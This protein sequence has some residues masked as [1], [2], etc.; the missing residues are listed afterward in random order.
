M[1]KEFVY[2]T[3]YCVE[4]YFLIPCS[5]KWIPP[6]ENI[7]EAKEIFERIVLRS[8]ENDSA[9]YK[10]ILEALEEAIN[11]NASL[12][13]KITSNNGFIKV[14]LEFKKRKDLDEF[15]KMCMHLLIH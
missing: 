4:Y 11:K 14:V 2:A 7:S 12:K 3:N 6:H 13:Q 15:E 5:K 9:Y 1:S 8:S 10:D